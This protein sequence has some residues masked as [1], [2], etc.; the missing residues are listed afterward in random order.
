MKIVNKNRRNK[1]LSRSTHRNSTE[2]QSKLMEN[3]YKFKTSLN[4]ENYMNKKHEKEIV[5]PKYAIWKK[6][7]HN[8][9][10]KYKF[11]YASNLIYSN[12]R[13]QNVFDFFGSFNLPNHLVQK[14]FLTTPITRSLKKVEHNMN[15][16]FYHHDNLRSDDPNI[17]NKVEMS[18]IRNQ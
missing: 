3:E 10:N 17:L 7:V 14:N 16:E 18:S 8:I 11:P 9:S 15:F 12:K 2:I 4:V 6:N 5:P 13:N 1:K